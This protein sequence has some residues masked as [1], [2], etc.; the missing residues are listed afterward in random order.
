MTLFRFITPR[1]GNLL[2][3]AIYPQAPILF[4]WVG[5]RVV[6][7]RLSAPRHIVGRAAEALLWAVAVVSAVVVLW[8]YILR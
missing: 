2:S 8:F 5:R 1:G 7:I 4:L 6:P 3:A